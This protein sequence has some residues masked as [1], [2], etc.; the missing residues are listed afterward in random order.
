MN[1][2][3]RRFLKRMLGAAALGAGAVGFEQRGETDDLVVTR[4]DVPLA[5]WPA[6]ASGLR[7]GQLTDMHCDGDHAAAR[8][9]RAVDMM[10]AQDPDVVFLTGDYISSGRKSS[11]APAAEALAALTTVRGGVFAVLGNHDCWDN[12]S[13]LVAGHLQRVGIPVLRNQSVPLPG[14]PDVWVV[15]LDDL[16]FGLSDVI[17]ALKT[18][19]RDAARILLVHEPD[20]A[21]FAPPGFAMQL[22]GHSHAGQIRVPGLPPLHCPEYGRRYPEGLQR[23]QHHWVYTSRGVGVM[24]PKFRLF[25]PPEVTVLRLFAAPSAPAP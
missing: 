10:L 4:R 11:A 1:P 3:R 12:R 8:T 6:S 14:R 22:S 13:N 2:A 25:C 21:D 24:G 18:V 9:R 17:Q 7:V 5:G 23:A 20:Y 19:P 15:G 16:C